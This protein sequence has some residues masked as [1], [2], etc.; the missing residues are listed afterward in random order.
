MIAVMTFEEFYDASPYLPSETILGQPLISTDGRCACCHP[1]SEEDI[2]Y[3][4][5]MGATIVDELPGDFVVAGV[6]DA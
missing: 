4:E 6:D 2:A 1:F 3:L 5:Y